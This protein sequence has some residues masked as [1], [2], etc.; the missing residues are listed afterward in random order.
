MI[1]P[2][3]IFQFHCS[4]PRL[5]RC[6][7]RIQGESLLCQFRAEVMTKSKAQQRSIAAAVSAVL[8]TAISSLVNVATSSP[9]WAVVVGLVMLTGVYA[10]L[11]ALRA[12]KGGSADSRPQHKIRI[13]TDR[14]TG[15]VIGLL[16]RGGPTPDADITVRTGDVDGEVTGY[17]QS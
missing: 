3:S 4:A 13:S 11:E 15:K 6:A 9:R 2:P 14:V 8:A 17:E 7:A 10:G 12:V 5:Q 1:G 16:L